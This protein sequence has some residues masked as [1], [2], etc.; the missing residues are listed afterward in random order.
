MQ[1]GSSYGT[2]SALNFRFQWHFDFVRLLE[3]FFSMHEST[4]FWEAEMVARVKV[5]EGER[6]RPTGILNFSLFS[7]PIWQ[8]KQLLL[9]N[10]TNKYF[11]VYLYSGPHIHKDDLLF[12]SIALLKL[13]IYEFIWIGCLTSYDLHDD[14]WK[15]YMKWLLSITVY[16]VSVHR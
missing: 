12:Q 6:I 11:M 9:H 4:C 14:D 8:R 13:M 1:V 2:D 5:G 15:V 3:N 7:T 16:A 10:V